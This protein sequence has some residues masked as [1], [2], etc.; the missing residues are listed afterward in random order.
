MEFTKLCLVFL[1]HRLQIVY[2]T[3]L[4]ISDHPSKYWAD[5]LLFNF[6]DLADLIVSSGWQSIFVASRVYNALVLSCIW[7]KVEKILKKN[8]NGFQRNHS[9]TLQ[10]LTL[11]QI[12]KGVRAKY[13]E[14]I[15]LFV[16][17]CK[18]FDS[19]HRRKME[20]MWI[21]YRLVHMNVP[22]LAD[23]HGLMWALCGQRMQPRRPAKNNEG[24]DGVRDSWNSGL[25]A[26]LNESGAEGR[27]F[28][29]Y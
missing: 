5:S 18:V 13:L 1:A 6:Y 7:P 8:Q 28:G 2:S 14:A 15:L 29:N 11:H 21:A 9:T 24:M 16:G 4:F 25:T 22:V 17:F 23:L 10:I 12:I 3:S 19:I 26:W 27:K 20:Q